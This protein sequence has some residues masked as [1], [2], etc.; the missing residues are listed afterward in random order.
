[1]ILIMGKTLKY[2]EILVPLFEIVELSI[3]LS[4]LNF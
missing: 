2:E 3:K 1:M 4:F